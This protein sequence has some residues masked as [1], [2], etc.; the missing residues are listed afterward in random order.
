[1]RFQDL[2]NKLGKN[3]SKQLLG[4]IAYICGFVKL[5]DVLKAAEIELPSSAPATP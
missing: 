5:D 3:L 2:K 1:M 4:I